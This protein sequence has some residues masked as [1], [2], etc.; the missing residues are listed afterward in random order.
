MTEEQLKAFIKKVQADDGLREKLKATADSDAVAAIAKAAG[1]M[2][3]ADDINKAQL[4]LSEEELE[5]A[6]G[7][8]GGWDP[9]N[10]F[11]KK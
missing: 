9:T 2:I 4:E 7:G 11:C 1:F 10:V 3:S 6:V 8:F 5:G